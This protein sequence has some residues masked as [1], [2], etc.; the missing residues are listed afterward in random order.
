MR[1]DL[2]VHTEYS[3]DSLI[4]LDDLAKLAG[5][6]GLDCLAITDHNTIRG[7]R[8]MVRENPPFLLIVGEEILTG[9]GEIIG[10]FLEEEIPPGLG[11]DVTIER[12]RAQDGVVVLPHPCDRLRRRRLRKELWDDVLPGMDLVEG[13]NGR[14]VFPG[15]DRDALTL[16]MRFRKP[17]TAGSDCH[18]PW[19][20]GRCGLIIGEF[21]TTA[22]FLMAVRQGTPFGYRAPPWVHAVTKAVKFAGRLGLRAQG[23]DVLS[24]HIRS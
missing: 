13:L 2:H 23:K 21:C 9:E 18:T 15:D 3:P 11:V 14:T 17:V 5:R 24:C 20:L 1:A 6:R 16:A 22:E 4:R 19:E 7:A 10:L 8:R 12:I